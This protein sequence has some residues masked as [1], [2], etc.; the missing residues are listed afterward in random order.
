M[1]GHAISTK[2][3][4][5]HKSPTQ[6]FSSWLSSQT[7]LF[8]GY[9]LGLFSFIVLITSLI[10]Y[11]FDTR[12]IL[13]EFIS[14]LLLQTVI[15][16][17]HVPF[18]LFCIIYLIHILD[19]NNVDSERVVEAHERIFREE[20]EHSTIALKR[21]RRLLK[22]FKFYFLLFWLSMLILYVIFLLTGFL[23]QKET[24]VATIHPQNNLPGIVKHMGKTGKEENTENNALVEVSE[25]KLNVE[26]TNNES[27][28]SIL[29]KEQ[30]P[31][32]AESNEAAASYKQINFETTYWKDAFA[33]ILPEFLPF[34]LN[35][36]S[37]MFVFWCLTILYI[38]YQ[39][40]KGKAQQRKL[41]YY[42]SLIV[43]ILIIS[44]PLLFNVARKS[45]EF[46]D[47]SLL[48]YTTVFNA[49]SG[50]LNAVVFAL[51]I[52]RLDSKLIGLRSWLVGILYLYAAVQPL[53]VVFSQ[54]GLVNEVIKT[55]V[56][57]LVFVFKIYF[58]LII[59]YA[60]QTGRML[61]YLFCFPTLNRRVNSMFDNSF[62]I[63]IQKKGSKSFDFIINK[64]HLLIYES[65]HS[66]PS[67]EACNAAVDRLQ[68]LMSDET[69]YDINPSKGGTFTV[70][71]KDARSVKRPVLCS[72]VDQ[73]SNDDAQTLIKESVDNIPYCRLNKLQR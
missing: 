17:A 8:I 66:F 1:T 59:I 4:P 67:R 55:V 24:Y 38:P 6:S 53:F 63:T 57:L 37:M 2:P 56:L 18:L 16:C 64:H 52:A 33:Y 48:E 9:L 51:L 22:E 58:F 45:G 49:I 43:F 47:L 5:E 41:I 71:I 28:A 10:Y 21:S 15:F 26:P 25:F 30:A 65:E 73:R 7:S 44:F 46:N 70:E 72:S 29:K 62:E 40:R 54:P 23:K 12:H 11:S 3:Q 31:A 34:A 60:M 39:T 35:T 42:S 50:T 36:I 14:P 32:I 61:N 20:M 19:I 27:V 13:A 69:S 68:K